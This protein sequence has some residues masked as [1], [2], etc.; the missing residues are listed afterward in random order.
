[1]KRMAV[2][3]TVATLLI[4]PTIQAQDSDTIFS[5]SNLVAWCIVPFDAVKRGPEARAEMLSRMGIFKLA[6]DWRAEHIPTFD[7]EIE[8]LE[9]WGIALQAFWF[10][11]ALNEDAKAIL[12]A[13]KR[14][15]V[16]TELWVTFSGGEVQC[17]PEEQRQRVAEH[18]ELIRPIVEAA[19]AQG[20]KVGLY[21]H[22]GWFGEPENQIAII[23]ALGNENVGIVY[24]QHHG[25]AHVDRFESLMQIM[26]PYLYCVNLNGMEPKGDEIGKKIW[27]IGSGSLDARLLRVIRNSGYKGPIGILNHTELDAEKVL[28]D[29]L[30]GLEWMLPQLDGVAPSSPRPPLR[31]EEENSGSIPVSSASD[32]FGRAVSGGMVADGDPAYREPPI[33]VECWARLVDASNFNVLV[34]CDTKASGTHWEMFTEVGT[35]FLA[36]YTPGLEPD[37]LRTAK[38]VTD[39]RWRH[40]AM[41]YSDTFVALYADGELLN[42]QSIRKKDMPPVPGGLGL[43]RLVEG[44]FVAYGA[45]D[46]VRITKGI[47][48]P[49]YRS[50]PASRDRDTIALWDFDDLKSPRR[51]ASDMEFEN[52]ARRRA[53]PERQVIPAASVDSLAAAIPLPESQFSTWKRSHGN[54]H[55][56]RFSAAKQINRRNVHTL[57]KAWEYR[58]GDTPENVQC[59]PIVVDGMLIGPTSGQH[60]VAIDGTNGDE[61]W[62][63]KPEG[64]PAHRGLVYWPGDDSHVARILFPSG[65]FIYAVALESGKPIDAFGDGGRITPGKS[66]VAPVVYENVLVTAGYNR[67]LWGFDVRTG[68]RIWS[69]NTI[70]ADGEF[71]RDTWDEPEEGAN[72]WGGIALD[73]ARGIVYMSTGSPKPNF[74]GNTH[75]GQNLFANCVIA[76]DAKTGN[77]RWHFQEIRHDI[78]D[79]DIPA[80]P[81]LASID[82]K[83]RRVDVVAQVTKIGNTLLLDR[84]TGESLFPFV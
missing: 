16:K 32:S 20:C 57:T 33:T 74:A 50:E 34:A 59:N 19:A 46:H 9:R 14:H 38:P 81:I 67:D 80:P 40:I 58:S 61:K 82:W 30:D 53:L 76:V 48:K 15:N 71:A 5:R 31:T 8:T 39:G 64:R 27:P 55:N 24:N 69:F 51:S 52:P 43:G 47:R 56:T 68:E 35:G 25:H 17:S 70:P 4:S 28:L 18:V 44:G 54:A 45:I 37:H 60:V 42:Q 72:C 75:K 2:A 29:N 49:E 10:P 78:W 84:E 11:G 66:V 13:L 22:G 65:E 6:Y 1:M 79:L 3:A 12:D 63:M 41:H 26:L 83:G 62:R 21:N 73:E 23:K 7:E 36:L 77:R